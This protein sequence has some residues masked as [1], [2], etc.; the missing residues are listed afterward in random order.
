MHYVLIRQDVGISVR[1]RTLRLLKDLII[2]GLQQQ[3]ENQDLLIEMTVKVI[4]RL[5]DEEDT[6]QELAQKSLL[7]ILFGLIDKTSESTLKQ[8][9]EEIFEKIALSGSAGHFR[10]LNTKRQM[11]IKT[12]AR[13]INGV[14]AHSKAAGEA[15]GNYI[16]SLLLNKED[17]FTTGQQIK[18]I[19]V[20]TLLV[21]CLVDELLNMSSEDAEV[22]IYEVFIFLICR[23]SVHGLRLWF[24][25]RE[26]IQNSSFPISVLCTSTSALISHLA[27]RR[28]RINVN[29]L[30]RRCQSTVS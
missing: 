15:I 30:P 27:P 3:F 22:R 23:I 28:I 21:E 7:A 11:E 26:A 29:A 1:K 8:D 19:E 24:N 16:T 4:G 9:P 14:V 20:S 17:T 18:V 13:L 25:S 10:S 2:T 5:E 12:H 6:V